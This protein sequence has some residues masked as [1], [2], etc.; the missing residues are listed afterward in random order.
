MNSELE[1]VAIQ[2][3]LLSKKTW[4]AYFTIHRQETSARHNTSVFRLFSFKSENML[5]VYL[6]M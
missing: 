6:F 2:Q 3:T 1:T 4:D 5:I